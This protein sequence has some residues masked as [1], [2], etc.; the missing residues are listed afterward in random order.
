[1]LNKAGKIQF[2]RYEVLHNAHHARQNKLHYRQ[3]IALF[4][5]SISTAFFQTEP[6]PTSERRTSELVNNMFATGCLFGHASC[7]SRA[8]ILYSVIE[9]RVCCRCS[10]AFSMK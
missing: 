8:V 10:L 9:R 3:F 1:M 4:V 2:L 5:L 7:V 6:R